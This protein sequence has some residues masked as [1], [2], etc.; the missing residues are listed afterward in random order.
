[1]VATCRAS[2]MQGT[3]DARLKGI[4]IIVYARAHKTGVDDVIFYLETFQGFLKV[5]LLIRVV[6]KTNYAERK[7]RQV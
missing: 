4:E 1:M 6:D 2:C 3:E 7:G 5:K